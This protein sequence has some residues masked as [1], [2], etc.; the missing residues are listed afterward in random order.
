MT[1]ET[2]S[3][4]TATEARNETRQATGLPGASPV[5][6]VEHEQEFG[7]DLRPTSLTTLCKAALDD[8]APRHPGRRIEYEPDPERR[9][10]GLWDPTRIAYGIAILLEDAILRTGP[11][12]PVQLRFR[13]HD[14]DLVVRVQFPRP[15]AAGDRIVSF[16]EDGIRPDGVTDTT[17]TLRLIVARKIA[18]QHGGHL[19]RVRTR[20]GTTYIL[21]LPR[22]TAPQRGGVADSE[23]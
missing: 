7:L 8:V 20:A 2:N 11:E 13:E 10:R 14:T 4:Q 21:T 19:A 12:E 15:L 3:L 1:I 17:G 16:F 6:E 18:L 5:P 23:P 9:G 22:V